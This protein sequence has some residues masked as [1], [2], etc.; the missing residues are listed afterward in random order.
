MIVTLVNGD[1]RERSTEAARDYVLATR[2]RL[3]AELESYGPRVRDRRSHQLLE[4][5]ISQGEL[6]RLWP[7]ADLTLVL[8]E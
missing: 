7:H 6:A 3:Q 5:S 1:V 4:H 2:N 8:A